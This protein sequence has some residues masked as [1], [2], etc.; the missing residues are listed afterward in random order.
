[1]NHKK[2]VSAVRACGWIV[3]SRENEW[4][5]TETILLTSDCPISCQL[6]RYRNSH[7]G[8]VLNWQHQLETNNNNQM[9]CISSI[10]YLFIGNCL[11]YE[12]KWKCIQ[13]ANF[14]HKLIFFQLNL[15]VCLFVVFCL[16]FLQNAFCN[17]LAL[18]FPCLF[19]LCRYPNTACELL[20]SDVS[21]IND[22]LASDRELVDQ[23][24][25]FLESERPLNPLLASFFSKVMG[26]LITRKSE[27]VCI[28][29][30][31]TVQITIDSL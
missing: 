22:K 30:P 12:V 6:E 20:T 13:C 28:D 16:L 31:W 9:L 23:L 25:S 21:Q 19:F 27:M 10:L 15:F 11:C 1:M 24:Y 29:V 14:W 3:C 26:L 8:F 2:Y 5:I 4:G 17:G 18:F 7:F